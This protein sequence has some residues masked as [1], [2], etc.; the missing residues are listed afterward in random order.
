VSD[1]RGYFDPCACVS[2]CGDSDP[3]G[4]GTCKRLPD[5]PREPLVEF[6][7]VHRDDLRA[8]R[9]VSDTSEEAK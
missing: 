6:Y 4:D 5:P 2:T 3:D 1:N 8:P 7:V 9:A